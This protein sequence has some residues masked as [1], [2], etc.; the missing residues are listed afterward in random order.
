MMDFNQYTQKA[1][2]RFGLRG[3]NAV[4]REL[5]ITTASM[6][7]FMS[8]KI[9]PSEE[10][11]IKLAELAGCPKEEAL[12][13]LNL[14]RSQ[15]D[16]ARLAIWQRIAKKFTLA[17]VAT[18][19]TI[20]N[21]FASDYYRTLPQPESIQNIHYATIYN[22]IKRLKKVLNCLFYRIFLLNRSF[23]YGNY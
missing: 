3:Q 15:N 10:T 5:N 2:N 19:I 6:S 23:N 4:A 14:W 17:V 7:N 11:M 22:L 16:P 18:L 20:T 8:G 12:I 9:L 13:D 1:I 21:C